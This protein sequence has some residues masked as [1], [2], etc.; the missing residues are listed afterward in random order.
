[1]SEGP[2]VIV[3]AT[4]LPWTP[5]RAGVTVKTLVD[6]AGGPTT[7]LVHVEAGQ[8]VPQHRHP[9]NEVMYIIEGEAEVDGHV[10]GPGTCIFRPRQ[11]PHGPFTARTPV[12]LILFFD[13]V[14][15]FGERT[16]AEDRR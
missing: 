4:A 8:V 5:G 13:G 9:A 16:A 11:E 2:G 1:M 3:D 14:F 10:V 6:Q 12:T 7:R 15:G